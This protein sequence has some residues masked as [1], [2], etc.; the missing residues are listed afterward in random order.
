MRTILVSDFKKHCVGILNKV[1]D[2][3]TQVVVTKRGKPLAKVVPLSGPGVEKRKPGDCA[4]VVHI[5]GDIIYHDHSSEWE[6]LQ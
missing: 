1:H 6:S 4:G 2:Q 5:V 3:C